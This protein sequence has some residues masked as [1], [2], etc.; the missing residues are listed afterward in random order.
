M[1]R[2][3]GG[4]VRTRTRIPMRGNMLMTRNV[5]MVYLSGQVAIFIKE[6]T[7]RMKETEL[8]R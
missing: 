4:R 3:N 8:E 5:G 6:T 2:V 1:E 7:Q